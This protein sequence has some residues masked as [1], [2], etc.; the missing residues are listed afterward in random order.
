M[1]KPII[2]PKIGTSPSATMKVLR[3]ASFPSPPVVWGAGRCSGALRIARTA[4]L[5]STATLTVRVSAAIARPVGTVQ[6]QVPCL[7]HPATRVLKANPAFRDHLL[8]ATAQLVLPEGTRARER[9]VLPVL[10][11]AT[12]ELKAPH[13][14]I[15]AP[16]VRRG[17]S[18]SR[19]PQT[20]RS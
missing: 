5:E 2:M 6:L 13:L 3:S 14:L 16:C 12:A 4:P 17:S 9:P 1:M 8:R 11:G 20:A 10:L 15:R 19:A 7:S 18:V